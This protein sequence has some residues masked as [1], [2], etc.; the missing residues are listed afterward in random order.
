MMRLTKIS[1]YG[2]RGEALAFDSLGFARH[3]RDN[4]IPQGQSEALADAVRNF[5]MVNLATQEDVLS[6]RQDLANARNQLETSLA[7]VRNQ[8]E[9]SLANA[10]HELEASLANVRNE[11]QTSWANAKKELQTAIDNLALRLTVRLGIMLA[12]GIAAL[13]AIVKLTQ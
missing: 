3:L 12:A 1:P 13:G 4:G 9:A 5:V 11:Q 7:N 8:L 6:V 2:G 10:R